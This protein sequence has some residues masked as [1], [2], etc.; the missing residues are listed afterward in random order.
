AC[1][2]FLNSPSPASALRHSDVVVE[3]NPVTGSD[4]TPAI[5][6]AI[7]RCKGLNRPRLVFE[8]GRYDLYASK[9]QQNPFALVNLNGVD[10]L[11]IDGHGSTL[12]FHGLTGCFSFGACKNATVKNLTIDWDRPPFSIGK[13]IAAT[14]K[15]FDVQ[16]WDEFPV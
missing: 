11:T 9:D 6:S 16:V 7:E 5:L 4:D 12:V 13:V 15:T 14:G 10:N 3:T 2:A 8:R 1:L